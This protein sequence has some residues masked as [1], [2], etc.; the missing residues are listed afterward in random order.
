[1][2]RKKP[3]EDTGDTYV[4]SMFRELARNPS[5]SP[6]DAQT[7]PEPKDIKPAGGGRISRMFEELSAKPS[8]QKEDG[9]EPDDKA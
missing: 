9:E 6:V 8:P 2:S 5:V 4:S 3:A 7:H 1:L